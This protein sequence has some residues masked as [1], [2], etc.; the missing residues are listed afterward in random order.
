MAKIVISYRRADSEAVTGRI[1]DRLVAHYGQDSVF[2]DIDSIPFG[3]DFRDY[4]KEAL[5]RTDVLIAV[6]GSA[7]QGK[8]SDGPARI[9]EEVD[10]VRIEVETALARGIAVI[11][12]LIDEAVMPQP[13]ELPD[14]LKNL[15]FRNAAYVDSGRDFHLHMDRLIRSM[16]R[17][18]GRVE[19][20]RVAAPPPTPVAAMG[21]GAHSFA[22]QTSPPPQQPPQ[23]TMMAPPPKRRWAL[24]IAIGIGTPLSLLG[25]LAI[26]GLLVPSNPGTRPATQTAAAPTPAVSEAPPPTPAQPAAPT[27]PPAV[28]VAA[29]APACKVGTVLAFQDDFNP[30]QAGWDSPTALRRFADGQMVIAPDQAKSVTWLNQPLR[31]QN[32]TVC[33]HVRSPRQ[34]NKVDGFAKGGIAFAAADYANYYVA[35]IY[36]DGTFRID[37]RLNN[38]W[39]PVVARTKTPHLRQGLDAVNEL[40]V[41]VKGAT[42]TADGEFYA[43]GQK[44]ADFRVQ[45]PQNPGAVG[46]YAES[47]EDRPSEWRFLNIAVVENGA[48]RPQQ[49]S[50]RSVRAAT[51]SITCKPESGAAFADDFTKTDLG[52]GRLPDDVSRQNGS[53]V[54]TLKQNVV[55]PLIYLSLRYSN[56]TV[57][58]NFA[59]PQGLI[60]ENDGAAAGLAFWAP[61]ANEY[62]QIG[63]YRN[64]TYDVYRRWQGR[65]IIVQPRTR[66]ENIRTAADARNQI[67]LH[68]V[69]NKATLYL[70]DA[71]TLEFWG[72]PPAGGGAIGLYAQADK[73]RPV[74]WRFTEIMVVD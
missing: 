72:Q 57:C 7:W 36:I 40:Q 59:W 10:P 29:P 70:N 14:S 15:A 55:R 34:V 21:A 38:E 49:A 43:N 2:M 31:F 27:P 67:K 18:L 71:R 30:P 23:I 11:P 68:M 1:R 45:Q 69:N 66:S 17:L 62:Y 32:F 13:S 47:E 39:I 3:I 64:G 22:S 63:V 48:L 25:A 52:W 5:D 53:L 73:E 74:T 42:G 58:T 65:W 24:W 44:I 16:D 33:A 35:H 9:M 4:I 28:Q 41:T 19:E 6:M 54:F 46:L 12:L 20:A 50:P 61:N 26:I 60:P 51:S 37:R 56:A 8:M